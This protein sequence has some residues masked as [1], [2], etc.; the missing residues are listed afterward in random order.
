MANNLDMGDRRLANQLNFQKKTSY[1]AHFYF[2]IS[3]I[4]EGKVATY[5][6]VAAM[7]GFPRMARAV[8][9]ALKNLPEGSQLPW[10]RV[11]NA[12]GELSFPLGSKAYQRQR[13]LLE[14]EGVEFIGYRI[15][16]AEFGWK[17]D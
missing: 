3:S 2:V 6:Q 8:G 4:P 16:L 13:E 1:L 14:S 9:R 17:G 15:P 12:K 11:I 5:G 7:A 10:Y